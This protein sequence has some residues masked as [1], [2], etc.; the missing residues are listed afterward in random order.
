MKLI[1]KNK[2]TEIYNKLYDMQRKNCKYEDIKNDKSKGIYTKDELLKALLSEQKYLCAYCM[3][4]ID[5]NN[6]SIEHIIGQNYIDKNKEN[7]GEKNQIN[8]DNLLAVCDGKSCKDTLHC[9][10][11]RAKYQ[12]AHPI[13]C[14]NPLNKQKMENIKFTLTG[15]I[16]YKEYM[17]LENIC[18][19]ADED[20][21]ARYDL[22]KVLNLNCHNLKEKRK[23]LINALKKKT[24]NWTKKN[25]IEKLLQ[26]YKSNYE[27]NELHQVAIYFLRKNLR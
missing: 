22:E 15:S 25:Q 14:A 27:H 24:K 10:K 6:A 23:I 21:R 26:N 11:S 12:I 17:K 20:M 2:S 1:N 13:L 5:I 18:D 19:L 7:I 9:D 8:Y 3:R 4:K 16:Y